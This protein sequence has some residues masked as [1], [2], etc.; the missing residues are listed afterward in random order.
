[1]EIVVS[2]NDPV[3]E[4]VLPV[5]WAGTSCGKTAPSRFQTAARP[6]PPNL[7]EVTIPRPRPLHTPRL[8]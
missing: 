8:V 2:F 3:C 4:L 6:L 7:P 5:R 1:M